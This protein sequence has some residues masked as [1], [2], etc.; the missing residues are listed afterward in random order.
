MCILKYARVPSP[1]TLPSHNLHTR[2]GVLR[3]I[4]V[5]HALKYASV[6]RKHMVLCKLAHTIST[7]EKSWLDK[8]TIVISD[9]KE[10]DRTLIITPWCHGMVVAGQP[11]AFAGLWV[12]CVCSSF[13][14]PPNALGGRKSPVLNHTFS[15]GC[16]IQDGVTSSQSVHFLLSSNSPYSLPLPEMGGNHARHQ[17]LSASFI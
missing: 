14:K 15:G 5:L 6:E 3:S 7:S 11:F 1:E 9:I 4:V 16:W 12:Q 10:L 17:T 8:Q 13:F 2:V